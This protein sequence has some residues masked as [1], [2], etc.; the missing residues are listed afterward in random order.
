MQRAQEQLRSSPRVEPTAQAVGVVEKR[1][2]PEGAKV[3]GPD[4]VENPVSHNSLLYF[5]T[6]ATPTG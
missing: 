6:A 3:A 1:D 2:S 5:D 4:P